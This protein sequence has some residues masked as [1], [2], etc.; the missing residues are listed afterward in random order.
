MAL[1]G[2]YKGV[3]REG[4]MLCWYGIY[5]RLYLHSILAVGWLAACLIV[6]VYKVVLAA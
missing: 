2:L 6:L 1:K 5:L 4:V 3:E